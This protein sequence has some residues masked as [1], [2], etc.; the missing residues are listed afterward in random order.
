MHYSHGS[1]TRGVDKEYKKYDKEY[2]Q[3]DQQHTEVPTTLKRQDKSAA[4]VHLEPLRATQQQLG[5]IDE[6]EGVR[7]G[8]PDARTQRN[9]CAKLN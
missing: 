7:L 3:Y 4:A 8:L 5:Q 9:A 2:K 1:A 6:G